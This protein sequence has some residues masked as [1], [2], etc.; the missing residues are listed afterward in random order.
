MKKIIFLTAS[1]LYGI[2]SAQNNIP[3]PYASIGK[4]MPKVATLTNG[5]YDE[6]HLQTALVLING[7]AIDRKT[8]ELVYSEDTHPRQIDSLKKE[9]DDKFRFLSVD[10][11]TKEYANLTPYQFAHNT[12]V[13]GS[14][15]DGKELQVDIYGN[16]YN[17]PIDPKTIKNPLVKEGIPMFNAIAAAHKNEKPSTAPTYPVP[18]YITQTYGTYSKFGSG[19]PTPEAKPNNIT[20]KPDTRTQYEKDANAYANWL[21][22]RQQAEP[23]MYGGGSFGMGFASTMG[24][25]IKVAPSVI[26]PSIGGE[27]LLGQLATETAVAYGISGRAF[28]ANQISASFNATDDFMVTLYRGLS[29][30]EE[31]SSALY[32]TDDLAYATSYA[33]KNG[34]QVVS[35][36]IPQSTMYLLKNEGLILTKNGIN[37]SG[38]SKAAT[39][40]IIENKAVKE[41]ILN[42]IK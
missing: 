22:E 4:H 18:T 25:T 40:F 31:G 26:I 39:E 21:K 19:A 29:G 34:T 8:G 1:I 20:F 30:T 5:A 13:I 23:F 9:L 32:L 17:G 35:Y 7:D 11:L 28:S 2:L 14:D 6:F 24:T 3:N 38:T 27:Y 33:T 15:L 36:N 12:P 37:T 41:A 42:T 16:K 10:P